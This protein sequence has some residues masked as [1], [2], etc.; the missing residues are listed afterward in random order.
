MKH[1]EAINGLYEPGT[2]NPDN[3]RFQLDRLRQ[4]GQDIPTQA[5]EVDTFEQADIRCD[6]HFK[7]KN[8][9]YRLLFKR[10]GGE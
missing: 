6:E 4:E 8:R 3:R 9:L 7:T 5:S 2:M 1:L 10:R